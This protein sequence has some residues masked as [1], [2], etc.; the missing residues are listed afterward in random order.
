MI[1]YIEIADVF[2]GAACSALCAE[3]RAAV[4][5]PAGLLGRADQKT[6][7]PE[8]RKTVRAE[9]SQ[10]TEERVSALLAQQK[11]ALERHFGL[12][13]GQVEKPQFLHYREGDFFVPH[14]DGNTPLIHDESRFRKISVV[15]FLNR[16][17][18]NPSPET[19]AGGSL[20]LH[21]PYSGPD[22]R[23][24]MPALPGSLVAFRS[25]TTHEVTP[26]TCN[27]RF[28]IVSWYRGA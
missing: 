5:R 12:L 20:V 9:V 17:S 28:T 27:E 14:Q 19:Y 15:I 3:I 18:D 24:A 16:Q 10:A 25:E 21:G 6:A 2:D 26:V 23:I 1:D 13:L 8:I 22:L 4:S 7:W 11:A